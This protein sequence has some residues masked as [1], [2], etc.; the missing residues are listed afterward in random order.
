MI[1]SYPALGTTVT[2]AVDGDGDALAAARAAVDLVLDAFDRTCSRFRAD[3][4]LARLNRAQGRPVAVGQLLL[5]AVQV[6]VTAAQTTVGLVDPTIGR[7]LRLAGYDSSFEIV[8]ARD[9]HSF[10]ARFA[11]TPGWE[12]I[13]IDTERRTI[14]VPL[15]V[16][17]DL[18]ATAKALAAD[19]A[20][21]AA[22]G[23]AACG[24]LVAIGGDIAV[25]GAPPRGGWAI[26]I[27]DD[28][29]AAPEA[30][31]T[32]VAVE[33]GGLATSSTTVRR[34]RSGDGYLHHVI[35]PRTG[36]PAVTPWRT[37]SVAAPSCVDANVASTAAV[38]L[39]DAAL[40]WLERRKLPARLVSTRGD[41]TFVC[42]W[43]AEEAA[44]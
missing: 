39:G 31:Q 30:I 23:A 43:P 36:R 41:V 29:A 28:H 44:A 15:G 42:G 19:R 10:R 14:A 5:E 13:E 1:A 3:S 21:R 11:P 37:V 38:V 16:E 20:A 25:C 34:W 40:P 8:I 17:L 26:G 9:G 32:T 33:R 7:T 18:G 35:D 24:A 4:E 12:T 27:A 22:S 2:V 6:A